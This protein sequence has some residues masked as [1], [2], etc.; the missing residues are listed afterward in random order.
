[1]RLALTA[2]PIEG[3]TLTWG[4]LRP[5][6]DDGARWATEILGL[7]LP[8]GARVDVRGFESS[9]TDTGWP[10]EVV[11]GVILVEDQIVQARLAACY[12]FLEY[13][14]AAVAIAHTV[15]AL[16]AARPVLLATFKTGRPDWAADGTV[17]CLR[18][19]V[20]PRT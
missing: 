3:V 7:E 15:E 10:C 20:V 11:L 4:D 16:E 5:C 18:D 8:R 6:P 13:A 1:M 17:V 9:P 12:R 19:L 2:S 14:G